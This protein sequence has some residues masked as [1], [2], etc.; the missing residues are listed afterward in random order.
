MNA[1]DGVRDR[2][3]ARLK[4]R[5]TYRRWV[6]ITAL[7]GMFATSFPVTI[8][9]VSLGVIADDFGVSEARITWVIAAPLLAS[10]VAL[11][12]LGKMGD[13]YGQRRVFLA[14]FALATL[15][16]GLTAFAWSAFALIALRTLT[17]VI[18]A[19]TQPT[20]MAL[21]MRAY[22][23]EDRVKVLGWWSLVGAGAPSIGLVVG[24]VL[25]DAVGWRAVFA[26]QAVLAVVPVVV[27][28]LVLE[29]V[30]SDR[31]RVRFDV[32]GAITLSLA[33]GGIMFALTQ[34]AEWGW[35]HPGVIA[36]AAVSPLAAVAF[37]LV[38]RSTDTPLLPLA[39]LRR[40]NFVVPLI[41]AFF[42]GAAYVG[43]FVMTP[44]YMRSVLG[45]TTASI[46]F[47]M[48]L[49][50]LTYS[51]SSPLGGQ[52]GA[53]L[54]ERRGA[55]VGSALFA[56]SMAAFTLGSATR[57]V[58]VI[59]V[60]LVAQ[61][62]GN[63]LSRPPLTATLANAVDEDDLGL[64]SASQRMVQ[65]IGSA[66][67]ITVLTAVYGGVLTAGAFS[68]AFAVAFALALASLAAAAFVSDRRSQ[69]AESDGAEPVVPEP[70]PGSAVS[71]PAAQR[72]RVA[73][74]R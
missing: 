12:I 27:A 36:A 31:P 5:G 14:G 28:M 6:L 38:E 25:V 23:P 53:R 9:T 41:A 4:E 68:R 56:A 11:P 45:W 59:G 29:E 62:V 64:A 13:L 42:G 73:V 55:V 21:I 22:P 32:R 18:G 37:V 35:A 43:G 58:V 44:L 74:D 48:L 30:R 66:F 39:L 34:S 17:Q 40:R 24:G 3:V 50:P 52:L 63:G 26:V 1:V 20:A 51:L 19:A 57:V 65:Q 46:A 69:S 61:G 2:V 33:A 54:G 7:V 60:A 8:L 47:L 49:R 72:D 16:A 71:A 15:T 10:A 67:G 70:V